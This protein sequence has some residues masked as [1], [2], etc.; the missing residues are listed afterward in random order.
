[1]NTFSSGSS[2]GEIVWQKLV[3]GILRNEGRVDDLYI[4]AL[5][6]GDAL[7]DEFTRRLV[8][9]GMER[10]DC[11]TLVDYDATY[12]Q[13]LADVAFDRL[14]D[15]STGLVKNDPSEHLVPTLT[16]QHVQRIKLVRPDLPEMGTSAVLD[17]LASRSLR[18]AVAAE[19]LAF[20]KVH[21]NV[22]RRGFKLIGLG[23][24]WTCTGLVGNR[25]AIAL[26]GDVGWRGLR[27]ILH[28][29]DWDQNCLIL[30]VAL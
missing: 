17:Q 8:N 9:D 14:F 15:Y 2:A 25:C 29:R 13:L 24:M 10:N 30:A 1:M 16:G 4:L 11:P 3:E 18:P 12:Q 6:Q 20:A 26:D 23:S 27:L 7:I 28:D 21:P 5:P 19:T 22:Q